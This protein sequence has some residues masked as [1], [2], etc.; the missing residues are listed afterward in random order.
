[1]EGLREANADLTVFVHPCL[2]ADVSYAVRRQLS[3]LLFTSISGVDAFV[4]RLDKKHA[5]KVGSMIR[6]SVKSVDEELI[7]V[8]GS[9]LQPNTGCLRRL[10]KHWSDDASHDR[11]EAKNDIDMLN[12][13][14]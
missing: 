6:F 5:I 9:L 7:H 11:F 3:S 10:C 12:Q 8:T 13:K 2:S 4:S 1:M 14:S